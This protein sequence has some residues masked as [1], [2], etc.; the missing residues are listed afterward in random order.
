MPRTPHI[1]RT[2]RD[3]IEGN[4][5]IIAAGLNADQETLVGL[6]IDLDALEDRVGN[7]ESTDTGSNVKY[8]TYVEGNTADLTT[9]TPTIGKVFLNKE[10]KKPAFGWGSEWRL[11]DGSVINSSGGGGGTP[12]PGTSNAPTN[13]TAVVNP[14]GT[15][16][17]T[18]TAPVGVTVTSYKL[19]EDR[20]PNGVAGATALTTTSSLRT[21]LAKSGYYR[22]WVTA[23]VSGVESAASNKAEAWLPYGTVPGGGAGGIADTPAEILRLGAEGG[24]W[25]I[26]VGYPSGNVS[27]EWSTVRDGWSDFPYFTAIE[28]DSGV[29]FRCPM[30]GG[31]TPNSEYPRVELRERKSDG[32]KASWNGRSGTHVLSGVTKIT[33]FPEE[34]PE[35]VIA[36]IHDGDDDRIQI[37]A[38][39][40]NWRLRVNG[41]SISSSILEN[42]SE[43]TYV[44]WSIRVESGKVTVKINGDTEYSSS[45]GLPTSGCYFKTGCYPQTNVKKGNSSSDY[46]NVIVQKNSLVLSHS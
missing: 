35:V 13:M 38:T 30:N 6:D 8:L 15:I 32:S 4:T 31:T 23:L 29:Q 16:L 26:D 36:Q 27:K 9:V 33:H 19:Y 21:G 11:A 28:S 43:G 42:Y 20:S 40:D 39:D 24:Y 1:R 14:D 17:L 37:L 44:S 22:Y 45:P 18:W 25:S 3:G 7:L 41:S 12:G 10:T 34:K 46:M 2:Y 5:P